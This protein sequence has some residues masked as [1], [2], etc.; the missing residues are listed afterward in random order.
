MKILTKLLLPEYD[1]LIL[2]ITIVPLISNTLK[3]EWI[4]YY[5]I[6]SWRLV[7]FFNGIGPQSSS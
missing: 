1:M 3:F 7:F 4:Y 5:V 2:H 6:F